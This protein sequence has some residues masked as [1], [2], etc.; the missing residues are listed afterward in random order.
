MTIKTV[1]TLHS[2]ITNKLQSHEGFMYAHLVKFE[3]PI[4]TVTGAVAETARDYSYLTDASHN[5]SFD[6]GSS[7]STGNANG[8][9]TYVA[10][11]L[12]KVGQVSETTQAKATSMGLTIDSIAL[13]TVLSPASTTIDISGLTIT[14]GESWID[15][16]F[17][18]GDKLRISSNDGNNG[19]FIIINNFY[20]YCQIIFVILVIVDVPINFHGVAGD[21][22][23]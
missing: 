20:L 13:N 23:I 8:T 14:I 21:S 9:Q 10:E 17:T 7:D 22:F 5:I 1:R 2:T 12:L 19:K 6:D 18:E 3:K 16:G 11:R 4:K 15:A